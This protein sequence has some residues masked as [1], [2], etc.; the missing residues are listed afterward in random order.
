MRWRT[1]FVLPWVLAHSPSALA[2]DAVHVARPGD[3]PLALAKA[4]RVPVA[5]ILARNNHLDPCRIKVGDPILIPDAPDGPNVPGAPAAVAVL[6]DEETP[7][8]R[9]VVAAGDIPASIAARFGVPLEA[10]ARANPGLDSRSLAVG[11]VLT[12]P[13]IGSCP[14]PVAVTRPGEAAGVPLVTDFQ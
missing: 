13:P 5:A 9:Y 4:Y 11:R 3:T 2:A 12:I 8:L 6:P 14:P 10:L 1:L 7:G